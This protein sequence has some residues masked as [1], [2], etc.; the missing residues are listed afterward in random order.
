MTF[1][2]GAVAVPAQAA[3]YRTPRT[4]AERQELILTLLREVLRLQTE[5]AKLQ[6]EA[7]SV[8]R[9]PYE[10]VLFD[11]PVETKSFVDGGALTRV[12]GAPVRAIDQEIFDLFTGVI[13]ARETAKYVAEWRVFNVANSAVDAAVE[14]IGDSERYVVYVNRAGY[15]ARPLTKLSFAQ[16]FVHEYSHLLFFPQP[17]LITEYTDRFWT[18]ADRAHAEAVERGAN[19]RIASYYKANPDRFVTEY[20]TVS[21]EEDMAETFVEFVFTDRPTGTSI[22]DRKVLSFYADQTFVSVRAELRANLTKL[23]LLP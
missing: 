6:G 8:A 4:D 22:K 17:K 12:G 14:S 23:G 1:I 3:T 15:V 11:L 20:A 9:Q 10:S 5:L 13:G 21:P 7:G 18:E 2:I 19:S 16:L